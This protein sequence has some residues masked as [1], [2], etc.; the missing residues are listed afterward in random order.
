M[1]HFSDVHAGDGHAG[2]A[3][4]SSATRM[5]VM[6]AFDIAQTPNLNPK[7]EPETLN[8]AGAGLFRGRRAP[9]ETLNAQQLS[10]LNPKLYLNPQRETASHARFRLRACM[11]PPPHM[12]CMYPPPQQLLMLD[13]VDAHAG[14]GHT[15]H[16]GG[17]CDT[18]EHVFSSTNYC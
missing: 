5:R 8:P 11:Y 16:Q 12:T 15:R 7:P 6:D 4:S 18:V 3:S 9:T 13:F 1:L 14:D 10:M 2:H 17:F